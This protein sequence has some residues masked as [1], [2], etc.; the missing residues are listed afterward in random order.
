MPNSSRRI[1]CVDDEPNV[2]ALRKVLLGAAGYDVLVAE[3]GPRGLESFRAH[4]VDAAVLDY[5]MPGM[6]GDELG[7]EMRRL[8]PNVP[9]L[10]V[11]AYIDLPPQAVVMF[12]AVITKG[13]SPLRLL[14]EIELALKQKSSAFSS[15]I[16]AVVSPERRYIEVSDGLCKLVGYSKEELLRMTID[17]L[18]HPS[19]GNTPELFEQF[20]RDG[21]QEGNFVLQHKSGAAVPIRYRAKVLPDGSYAA[22]WFPIT[23]AAGQQ[24]R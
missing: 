10:L 18:T 1:L 15:D 4:A 17:A 14:Q 7:R 11:T 3:D 20:V 13:E 6:M 24:R 2:L 5:K 23:K 9:L 19:V 21:F 22:E 12:D 16:I 8:R